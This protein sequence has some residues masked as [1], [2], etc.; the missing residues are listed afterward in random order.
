MNIYRQVKYWFT[1]EDEDLLRDFSCDKFDKRD[2]VDRLRNLCT[3]LVY[4]IDNDS[5]TIVCDVRPK[6]LQKGEYR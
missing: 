3:E 2:D 5:R 4:A 1:K 6:L